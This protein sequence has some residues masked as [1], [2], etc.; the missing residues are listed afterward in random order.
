MVWPLNSAKL[1]CGL[2][3]CQVSRIVLLFGD[4]ALLLSESDI[5][6]AQQA[7]AAL[8]TKCHR[9]LCF[10]CRPVSGQGHSWR[11]EGQNTS[12]VRHWAA[13]GGRG[14][15]VCAHVCRRRPGLHACAR[16]VVSHVCCKLGQVLILMSIARTTCKQ[17]LIDTLR[18]G[19]GSWQ[20]GYMAIRWHASTRL[21]TFLSAGI[22]A[23]RLPCQHSV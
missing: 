3:W 9:T 18:H 7:A 10:K 16:L 14:H 8:L 5:A 22:I 2:R 21:G 11:R 13:R 1:A 23:L 4:S 17:S 12:D 15:C 19:S 20:A 6:C